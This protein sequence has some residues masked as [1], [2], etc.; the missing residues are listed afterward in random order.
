MLN[1]IVN[2]YIKEEFYSCNLSIAISLLKINYFASY[3]YGLIEGDGSIVTPK[4]GIKSYRPFFELVFHIDDLIL[5]KTIQSIIGG[6]IRINVNYCRLIIK[7]KASVL[8][9][10]NLINGHMR[11]PKI[12]AL[13]RMIKWFNF[14]SNTKIKLLNLDFIPLQNNSWLAVFIDADGYFY[15]NWL[16]DKKGI[17]T[18]LQYFM[19]ITQKMNYSN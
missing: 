5:A 2:L 19:R 3:L 8:N 15:F 7:K 13:H 6:N 9:I 17:P 16:F 10:I 11:T 18:S 1:F 12:E 4:K 14:N